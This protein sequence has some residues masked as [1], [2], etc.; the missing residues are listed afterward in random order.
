M[1]V[2]YLQISK[3]KII[4]NPL[5]TP[6]PHIIYN[7]LTNAIIV[8]SE[9]IDQLQHIFLTFLPPLCQTPRITYL[10]SSNTTI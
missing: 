5:T 9:R 1:L 2:A 7:N 10:T 3:A 6:F 4:K 8:A